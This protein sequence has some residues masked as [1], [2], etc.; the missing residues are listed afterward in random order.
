MVTADDEVLVP[1]P[2]VYLLLDAM[3]LAPEH[4]PVRNLV[5]TVFELDAV[6]APS[7]IVGP[8]RALMGWLPASGLAQHGIAEAFAEWLATTMPRLFPH[9]DAAAV[10]RALRGD[11]LKREGEMSQLAQRV[12]EWEAEWLRQGIE[13]GIAQG[14]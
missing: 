7:E 3:R 10:V 2:R 13:R 9:S 4:L 11:L 5:S 8:M 12:K 1:P 14:F 6:G